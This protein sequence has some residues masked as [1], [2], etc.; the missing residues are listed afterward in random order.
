MRFANEL[1]VGLAIVAS[2]VIFLLGYRYLQDV[3][4]LAGTSDYY[5]VLADAKGLIPGNP[6]RLNGVKVGSV[7]NVA[8]NS[9]TDSVRVDF[10]VN[11]DIPLEIECA[12]AGLPHRVEI[13]ISRYVGASDAMASLVLDCSRQAAG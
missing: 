2:A 6:V 12:R 3:P 11:K 7:V 10:K 5:S 13:E 8:Y 9:E 4:L 1:K